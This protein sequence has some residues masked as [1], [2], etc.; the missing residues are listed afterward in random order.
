MKV[1][2]LEGVPQLGFFKKIKKAVKSVAKTAV[3]VA[4]PLAKTALNVAA[5]SVPGGTAALNMIKAV[6]PAVNAVKAVKSTASGAVKAV[7]NAV[8]VKI[9]S[10]AQKTV[11]QVSKA[12][13]EIKKQDLPAD[14]KSKMLAE[15]ENKRKT[16]QAKDRALKAGAKRAEKTVY[17]VHSGRVEVSLLTPG[18]KTGLKRKPNL[19]ALKKQVEAI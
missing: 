5:S 12:I 16:E 19:E 9:I 17:I 1:I 3:K 13:E 6:A 18:E 7:V 4:S 11:S 2:T 14:V 10:E 8:P 15:L